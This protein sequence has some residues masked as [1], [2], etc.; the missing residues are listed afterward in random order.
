MVRVLVIVAG[1]GATRLYH[2]VSKPKPIEG[3]NHVM[4][5]TIDSINQGPVV[6]GSLNPSRLIFMSP[7]SS[8][9]AKFSTSLT[10]RFTFLASS[11]SI[12]DSGAVL[13]SC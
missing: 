3:E 2:V 4:R 9:I 7:I 1:S 10:H 12:Q 13:L 5:Q 8:S 6:L 11:L